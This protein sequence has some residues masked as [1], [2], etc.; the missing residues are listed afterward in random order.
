MFA[1]TCLQHGNT[2]THEYDATPAHTQRPHYEHE[3]QFDTYSTHLYCCA[4]GATPPLRCEAVLVPALAIAAA[5]SLA[6]RS[7]VRPE[8]SHMTVTEPDMT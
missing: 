1:A 6:L 2:P 5:S 7:N 3:G 8:G 4:R